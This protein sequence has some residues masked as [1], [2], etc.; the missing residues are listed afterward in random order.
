M[1]SASRLERIPPRRSR[2][3]FGCR[4]P[5]S[6]RAGS[7]GRAHGER[8]L[9]QL[10]RER[11]QVL[12]ALLGLIAIRRPFESAS[13][14]RWRSSTRCGYERSVERAFAESDAQMIESAL[15]TGLSSA[16]VTCAALDAGG[17][18]QGMAPLLLRTA[19]PR[20]AVNFSL[21]EE[22]YATGLVARMLCAVRTDDWDG[23]VETVPQ[24]RLELRPGTLHVSFGDNGIRFRTA[25]STCALSRAPPARARSR[26]P[27]CRAAVARQQHCGRGRHAHSLVFG[28]R[29]LATGTSSR[30]RVHVLDRALA[31]H[32]HNWGG[33]QWGRD[34]SWIWGYG[35][36]SS[37]AI[38]GRSRSIAS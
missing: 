12:S 37:R 22:N 10:A 1:P 3:N 35:H 27:P 32:D 18:L 34:F 11:E 30:D 9:Q 23:D 8:A 14:D 16:A 28:A 21:S 15:A 33:F 31:Y 29:L 2:G 38:R 20:P 25:A 13:P 5:T 4:A 24:N 26:A 36:P 19:E 6:A 7:A 17:P